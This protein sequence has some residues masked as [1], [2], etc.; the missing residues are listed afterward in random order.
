[1]S[2]ESQEVAMPLRTIQ[3]VER[4]SREISLSRD[5]LSVLLQNYPT[6]FDLA[7]TARRN[8]YRI[9]PLGYVGSVRLA[10][11]ILHIRPKIRGCQLFHLMG[12]DHPI[13][14]GGEITQG[15]VDF[16]ARRLTQ[17]LNEVAMIGFQRQYQEESGERPF[18][19]GRLD[20][21]AQMRRTPGSTFH[22][23]SDEFTF[24]HPLNR[25]PK[26]AAIA[27]LDSPWLTPSTRQSLENAIL[28]LA[29]VTRHSSHDT[30]HIDRTT[31][32]YRPLIECA[33][34][35]LTQL[36]GTSFLWNTEAMFEDYLSRNVTPAMLQPSQRIASVDRRSDLLFR[37]DIV[38]LRDG[39]PS[40]I[41][42]AKWK[43]FTDTP[44]P[45]DVHQ[46]LAYGELWNVSDV[47]LV[48]PGRRDDQIMFDVSDRVRLTVHVLRV[49]HSAQAC[50]RGI[51]RLLRSLHDG[52]NR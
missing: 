47:R 27:L 40:T 52:G 3:L 50:E 5:D 51:R 35:I 46:V 42:D 44:S 49:T 9:Q 38:L 24:D 32:H 29:E 48:Y 31:Q 18:L 37:P 7:P 17:S 4:Q 43:V 45:D 6:S 1:V 25:L 30:F 13:S 16:L 23:T 41:I 36:R 34:S 28:P 19:R 12:D 20:V 15:I 8:R 2:H 14:G 22:C 39:E 11:T 10:S 21:S 33:E 26:S